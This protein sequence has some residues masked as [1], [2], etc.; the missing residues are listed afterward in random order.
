MLIPMV[1]LLFIRISREMIGG[2]EREEMMMRKKK[3]GSALG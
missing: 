3:R 1:F 2:S